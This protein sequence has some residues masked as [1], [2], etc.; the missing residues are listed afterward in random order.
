MFARHPTRKVAKTVGMTALLLLTGCG[1][2]HDPQPV[3][4]APQK[5]SSAHPTPSAASKPSSSENIRTIDITIQG[6]TVNPPPDRITIK[7]RETIRL[8]VTADRN[9][10]LH[11]H[12]FE[13]ERK[14][15]AN[16]PTSVE[17]QGDTP[18]LY[19]VETHDPVLRLAQI[20][21]R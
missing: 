4:S 6:R 11:I 10:E 17:L 18:G 21:V 16:Q 9:D 13:I 2:T 12:G 3:Q 5:A 15:R 19:E 14:L 8:T 7:A 20:L 1:A